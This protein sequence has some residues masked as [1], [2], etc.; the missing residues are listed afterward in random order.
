MMDVAGAPILQ[1]Q[2]SPRWG[3][4]FEVGAAAQSTRT[5]WTLC[6]ATVDL[7]P[8]DVA[9]NRFRDPRDE[10]TVRPP[11][12]GGLHAAHAED[13]TTTV[14]NLAITYSGA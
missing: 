4:R 5:W 14:R 2:V 11:V 9:H 1:A 13:M 6:I 10:N 3:L 12:A 8:G 7:L